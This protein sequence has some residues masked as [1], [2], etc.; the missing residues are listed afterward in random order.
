[1]KRVPI[2]SLKIGDW[3]RPRGARASGS[4]L[5]SQWKI[6]DADQ[7]TRCFVLQLG[8]QR[9]LVRCEDEVLIDEPENSAR[10]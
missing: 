6:V 4:F 9:R 2:E 8:R 1:M 5:R 10:P 7:A 3:C